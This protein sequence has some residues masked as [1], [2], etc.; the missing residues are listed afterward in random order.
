MRKNHRTRSATRI[1]TEYDKECRPSSALTVVTRDLHSWRGQHNTERNTWKITWKRMIITTIIWSCIFYF[2]TVRI[3]YIVIM[4]LRV[5]RFIWIVI[6]IFC[7]LCCCFLYFLYFFCS[8]FCLSIF[9]SIPNYEHLCVSHG[10][11]YF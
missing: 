1:I 5:H 6:F 2:H 11:V 3:L 8:M 10:K 9:L 4:S 7:F